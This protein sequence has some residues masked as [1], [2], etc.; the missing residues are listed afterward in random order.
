MEYMNGELLD[1]R[2]YC[3]SNLITCKDMLGGC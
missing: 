3:L 2:Q 1:I